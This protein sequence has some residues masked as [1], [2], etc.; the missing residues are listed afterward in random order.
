MPSYKRE[1]FVPCGEARPST[2]DEG[3]AIAV[4][5]PIGG[6]FQIER[7]L[8]PE[9]F[10]EG[11]RGSFLVSV[12]FVPREDPEAEAD[13]VA[14]IRWPEAFQAG[15]EDGVAFTKRR[16]AHDDADEEMQGA[17]G[18]RDLDLAT[19]PPLEQWANACLETVGIFAF[20]ELCGLSRGQVDGRNHHNVGEAWKEAVDAYDRGGQAGARFTLAAVREKESL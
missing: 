6:P 11:A 13:A 14:R 9:A 16:I 15:F 12:T 2:E 18:I 17:L 20:G 1:T 5:G 8:P 7:C 4:V 3:S 10:A 19:L